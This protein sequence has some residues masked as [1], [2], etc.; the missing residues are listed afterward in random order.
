MTEQRAAGRLG[1]E[2]L[3]RAIEGR[4]AGMLAGL[5]AEDAELRIVNR[6]SPPSARFVLRAREAISD[7]YDDVCGRAMTHRIERQVVGEE[8]VAFNEECEYPDGTRVLC[9]AMLDVRDGKI[10]RQT[11][12]EV[13]DE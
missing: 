5:Y 6:N 10:V 4:D 12:V 11:N 2:T 1:F 3:R 9:A 13:W 8:R 7:Y